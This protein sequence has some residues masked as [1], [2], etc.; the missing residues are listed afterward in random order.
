M[1]QQSWKESFVGVV[2][3]GKIAE[4]GYLPPKFFR[5]LLGGVIGIQA[6]AYDDQPRVEQFHQN[7][8]QF[9]PGS[10]HIVGPMQPYVD[11]R[12]PWTNRAQHG[13]SGSQSD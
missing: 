11:S 12:K 1:I 10:E 3:A 13:Q 6:D 7:S 5:G 9:F 4:R 2:L 8:G